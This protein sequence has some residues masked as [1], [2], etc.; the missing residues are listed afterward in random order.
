MQHKTPRLSFGSNV[1][2]ITFA[3]NK[4]RG[5][6]GYH[7]DD[8]DDFVHWTKSSGLKLNLKKCQ[9]LEVNFTKTAPHH[10]DIRIGYDKLPCVD[11]AKILGVWLQNNLR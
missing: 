8:L 10:A 4:A 3:E 5:D 1:Y 6:P 7:Q 11:K 2:D 9:A